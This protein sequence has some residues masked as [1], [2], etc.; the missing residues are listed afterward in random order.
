MKSARADVA[1]SV[2]RK[3]EKNNMNNF[4]N[5]S[6]L[7]Y[8][9]IEFQ[10]RSWFKSSLTIWDKLY[11]IVPEGY[12]PS[13]SDEILEAIDNGLVENIVL[14]PDDLK[15]ASDGFFDFLETLEFNPAGFSGINYEARLHNN[16]LDHRMREYFKTRTE[17][18]DNEGFYHLPSEVA[19]GYMFFLAKGIAERRNIPKLT[20][21]PD[22][23]T[24]MSYFD[25]KGKFD[26]LISAAEGNEAYTLMTIETIIPADIP[27][28]PIS[29]IIEWNKHLENMKREFRE[30]LESFVDSIKDIEDKDFA[31]ERVREFK[32][33]LLKKSA[34][35]TETMYK[36]T[37]NIVPA[38]IV[39]GFP[40]AGSASIAMSSSNDPITIGGVAT[41]V[42]SLQWE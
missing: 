3:N 1:A 12:F 7:Y 5:N 37:D 20:D 4:S 29:K 30:E 27:Y 15:K 16:K 35:W 9:T 2:G 10:N 28:L 40:A 42:I 36:I 13:D 34:T 31:I 6:L 25:A 38:C 39:S 32:E 21:N 33:N 17:R 24:A 19:N 11:R 8:P 41:A 22:M 26:E 23:F 18:Y 14:H